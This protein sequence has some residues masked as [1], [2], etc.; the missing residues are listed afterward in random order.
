MSIIWFTRNLPALRFLEGCSYFL[1]KSVG[2]FTIAE[3]LLSCNSKASMSLAHRR[4][5]F[6]ILEIVGGEYCNCAKLTGKPLHPAFSRPSVR[7]KKYFQIQRFFLLFSILRETYLKM[8]EM[9]SHSV[10]GRIND[11]SFCVIEGPIQNRRLERL[12]ATMVGTER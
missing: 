12:S 3:A 2:I 5:S 10:S 4:C 9:R 6:S 1:P 7:V 11:Y 8:H